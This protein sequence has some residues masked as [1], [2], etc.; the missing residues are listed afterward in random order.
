MPIKWET[1][2]AASDSK[3][4]LRNSPIR[5]FH[6]ETGMSK[7]SLKAPTM[8]SLAFVSLSGSSLLHAAANPPPLD[9]ITSAPPAT[10]GDPTPANPPL[11]SDPSV[12]VPEPGN[13]S[14]Y[15]SDETALLKLG[16]ALFWDMQLGSDGIQACASCH[17]KAGA[18]N[19]SK[20][21]VS[22]G[23]KHQPAED[24]FFGNCLEPVLFFGLTTV[25]S[26]DPAA[27]PFHTPPA[28]AYNTPNYQLQTTDF[29]FFNLTN[30]NQLAGLSNPVLQD[31]ND[32]VSSQGVFSSTLISTVPGSAQD[33][34]T[35]TADPDGFI[36]NGV[37][38]RRVEPRNAP[39]VINTIFS[40]LQFWDGRAK[41]VFNGV[42]I[43]GNSTTQVAFASIPKNPSLVSISLD[44][45]A[46]ASLVS[47]PIV[48][49]NEMSAEG[50]NA[51]AIGGKFLAR[52]ARRVHPL[53][54]LG[55]Q[56][57][58]PTDSVLGGDA[59][60]PRLGLAFPSYKALVKAAFNSPW[61]RSKYAIQLNSDGSFNQFVNAAND[62]D[63]DTGLADNQFT[64]LEY[65]FNLFAGLAIQKYLSTLISDQTPFD[66]FQAGNTSALDAQQQRGLAIFVKSAANG[67][68]NCNTCHT[69][70]EGTRASVRRAT[71]VHSI[72]TS[73]A[74]A[75]PL[76]NNNAFGFIN[77]YGIRPAL[78]DPG[79]EAI[80]TLAPPNCTTPAA[81]P[82]PAC[83]NP[84]V[85]SKFKIP[86]LR[87][88]GL[89]A[90]YNHNG[91][92]STLEQVVDF[93]ARGRGDAGVAPAGTLPA[94]LDTTSENDANNQPSTVGANNKSALVAFLRNG[95]TDPR[96]LY[97]RAPFDHPQIMV[98]NGH[99]SAI[100]GSTTPISQGNTNGNAIATDQL[101][102]IPAVGAAGIAVPQVNFLGLP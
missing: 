44:N 40:K 42:D 50:R 92:K 101:L 19:R 21:Q 87:N 10:A 74:P 93:Y 51:H 57:V 20:N 43:S 33:S 66:A 97:E 45:S 64:F 56:L 82:L 1:R 75:D 67:G 102:T 71:G 16:K 72:D 78:D 98:P 76:I 32:V 12:A 53:R 34:V 13:L 54:P 80:T 68:G 91:G 79:A 30:P 8:L 94:L 49:I 9:N 39:T 63:D 15:V 29:P 55:Q 88:I 27:T 18:D 83:P 58:D 37:D 100:P 61:W 17:F 5:G 7:P 24:K 70:P 89:T 31:L 85:N 81:P 46:V 11:I 95:L 65:N 59:R 35:Y 6:E 23:L 52:K 28:N 41:E 84:L 47:G 25:C 99:P 3:G 90:P 2:F 77:N 48:S 62:D 38:T 73:P 22:P 36:I 4:A 96:V 14:T 69:L 60:S 26:T 86:N